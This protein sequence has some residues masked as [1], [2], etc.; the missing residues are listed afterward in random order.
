MNEIVEHARQVREELIERHGG[1]DG[2]FK[3]CQ[4]LD[5]ARASRS[6]LGV[7]NKRPA[8]FERPPRASKQ[9]QRLSA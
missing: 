2:Y 5:R 7:A 6:N 1:I 4:E 3:Y 9:I 8:Q